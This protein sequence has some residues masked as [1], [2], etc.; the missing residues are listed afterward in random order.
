MIDKGICKTAYGVGFMPTRKQVALYRTCASYTE[1]I[2]YFKD[3]DAARLFMH[4][5]DELTWR[6]RS[7]PAR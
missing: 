7:A 2:A 6:G 5:V 3:E 4:F 1:P